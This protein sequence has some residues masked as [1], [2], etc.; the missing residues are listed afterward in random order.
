MHQNH[1]L[2]LENTDIQAPCPEVL[3]S[4]T[5]RKN[6]TFEYFWKHSSESHMQTWLGTSVR[7]AP[8]AVTLRGS[9]NQEIQTMNTIIPNIVSVCNYWQLR[10]SLQVYISPCPSHLCKT[11]QTTVIT[12]EKFTE[13]LT[14]KMCFSFCSCANFLFTF[15]TTEWFIFLAGLCFWVTMHCEC[16]LSKVFPRIYHCLWF[17]GHS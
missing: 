13:R 10:S 5:C 1:Q 17:R 2:L 7:L 15:I 8:F 6:Q 9:V 4:L 12:T 16:Q 11:Q 14:P 3:I